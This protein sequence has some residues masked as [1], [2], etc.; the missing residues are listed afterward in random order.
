MSHLKK[1]LQLLKD[2]KRSRW[3]PPYNGSAVKDVIEEIRS[4]STEMGNLVEGQPDLENLPQDIVAGLCLYNDLID[5]NRRCLLAYLNYRLEMIES[6]RW[7]VGLM[8]PPEKLEKLHDSEKTYMHLYNTALDRYTKNYIPGVKEP[9]DLTLDAKAPEEL[10]VQIKVHEEVGDI[11]TLDSGVLKLHKGDCHNV[12]RT[13]IEQ[14]IRA[15]K[16]E[17]VKSLTSEGIGVVM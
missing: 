8:V 2:L 6:L 14:L 5:R 9:L 16:V 3:L 10:I 13:D 1:S 4:H 7:E 15:G 11:V 17:H 12:K